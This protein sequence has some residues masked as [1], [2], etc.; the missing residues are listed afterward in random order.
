MQKREC[1]LLI[2]AT[3]GAILALYADAH[4]Q[5]PV[6]LDPASA[7]Q[8]EINEVDVVE[9]DLPLEENSIKAV[10]L[11]LEQIVF[12][13]DLEPEEWFGTDRKLTD[14]EWDALSQMIMAEARGESFEVQYYIACVVLNRVDSPLFPNTAAGVI[15]QTRPVQ[16]FGA[17]DK[18]RYEPTDAVLEA[19]QLALED[20]RTPSELF[21]FTS[22]GWLPGTEPWLQVGGM[23]FSQQED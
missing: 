7:K 19:I 5:E 17:W 10:P 4:R 21:Y 8:I 20:N 15:Y 1:L 14:F 6:I 22:E 3:A 2:G 13:S 12:Q 23:W 9:T 11:V 18:E 16:F